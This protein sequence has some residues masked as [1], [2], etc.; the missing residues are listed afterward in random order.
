MILFRIKYERYIMK[1]EKRTTQYVLNYLNFF[2]GLIN[3]DGNVIKK[4]SLL[5]ILVICQK[6]RIVEYKKK[7][8]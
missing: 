8:C 5:D 2:L 4:E 1:K 6:E 7:L 3:L